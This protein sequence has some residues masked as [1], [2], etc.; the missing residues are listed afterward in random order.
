MAIKI[1]AAL[2]ALFAMVSVVPALMS[3][4]NYYF[5]MEADG[6]PLFTQV[7]EWE[8]IPY[9]N[10]YELEIR[11][12]N[13]S[14]VHQSLGPE[15]KREISLEPGNYQYRISLYNIFDRL[16]VRG[17]WYNLQIKKAEIPL[18]FGIN[19]DTLYLEDSEHTFVL[20]G[21][22]MLPDSEYYLLDPLL[23]TRRY[24]IYPLDSDT[25]KMQEGLVTLSIQDEKLDSGN[26]IV[27]MFN[28]GGLS[29]ESPTQLRIRYG[30]PFELFVSLAYAPGIPVYDPWFVEHWQSP[31]Y[32]LGGD[33]RFTFIFSK[34]NYGFFGIESMFSAQRLY[35]GD[36]D[37]DIVTDLLSAGLGFVYK[38]RFLKNVS[39]ITR[40]H[41]GV[42]LSYLKFMYGD[43]SGNE[44]ASANVSLS[45][46]LGFQYHFDERSAVEIGASLMNVFYDKTVFGMLRPRI[47]L[48]FYF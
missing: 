27:Q 14:I 12:E 38:Y 16:E 40:V 15:P 8:A 26:Y 45:A 35:G 32:F 33:A 18:V 22:G 42:C 10:S 36:E 28:P 47:A 34:K 5:E 7:I 13:A 39:V 43:I 4:E 17:P 20:Q 30:R 1:K 25:D 21:E 31:I 37:S 19:P 11:D 3:Q 48:V 23:G 29:A 6:T 41:P 46:D 44:T 9:T 2:C 24:R